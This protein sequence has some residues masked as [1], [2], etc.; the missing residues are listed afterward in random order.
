MTNPLADL[1]ATVERVRAERFPVLPSGLVNSIL[2]I[3]AES[4]E[5]RSEAAGRISVVIQA[6]VD[7]LDPQP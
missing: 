6:Y 1:E 3:E 2:R 5:N 4:V 7:S